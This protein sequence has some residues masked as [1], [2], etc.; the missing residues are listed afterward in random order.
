MTLDQ[1]SRGLA[2]H[3][4]A[5]AIKRQF[6]GWVLLA[7]DQHSKPEVVNVGDPIAYKKGQYHRAEIKISDAIR[8]LAFRQWR[9]D[10]ALKF[11]ELVRELNQLDVSHD[12]ELIKF[13]P[14]TGDPA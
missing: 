14:I 13:S 8:R 6:D 9:K 5:V 1:M 4:E 7:I 3:R 12:L 10:L 2:A 11:N